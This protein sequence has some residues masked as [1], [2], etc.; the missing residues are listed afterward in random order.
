MDT[1]GSVIPYLSCLVIGDVEIG[2]IGVGEEDGFVPLITIGLL[3]VVGSGV[4]TGDD[5]PPPPPPPV[6]GGLGMLE[7]ELELVQ[8]G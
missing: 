1:C 2:A 5:T 7:L 6:D 4:G 3:G 8:Q